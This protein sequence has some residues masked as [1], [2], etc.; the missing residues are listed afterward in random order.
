MPKNKTIDYEAMIQKA[1]RQVTRDILIEV[2]NNGLQGNHH[3]Y[4]TFATNHP[5]VEIPKHLKEEYPDEMV[6]VLQHEFW[7]LDVKNDAFS[8]TLCFDELNERI[9][10]PFMALIN[11]VDPSIKFGLQFLPG[12]NEDD[13]S[14]PSKNS[15]SKK[16]KENLKTNVVSLDDFRNK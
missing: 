14:N 8:V 16:E 4:I 7:D 3:F 12:Y 11:F 9:T 10:V 13:E 1:L 6:I 2:A 15:P 5:W